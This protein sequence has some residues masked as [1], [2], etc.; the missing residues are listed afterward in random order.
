MSALGFCLSKFLDFA[1]I[2][3]LDDS[4]AKA[5]ARLVI[6][7]L[8]FVWIATVMVVCRARKEW[9]PYFTLSINE[10]PGQQEDG[11]R[12]AALPPSMTSMI[13]HKFLFDQEEDADKL[14][15][16]GS[17]GSNEAVMIVNPNNY[18]L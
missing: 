7:A 4:F 6:Q 10:I 8:D 16:C 5:R 14:S 15:D 18:T 17:V 11:S 13:T 2:N 1:L 9:P 3:L 12:Q